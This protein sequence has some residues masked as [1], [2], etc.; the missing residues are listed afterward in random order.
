M[1]AR[2]S[3]NRALLYDLEHFSSALTHTL[4]RSFLLQFPEWEFP[5]DWI[6]L[7]ILMAQCLQPSAYIRTK[8]TVKNNAINVLSSLTDKAQWSSLCVLFNFTEQLLLCYLYLRYASQSLFFIF[9][10]S[11]IQKPLGKSL[12]C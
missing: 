2:K 11:V 8:H 10:I 6:S 12:Y 1:D 9:L 4:I 3:H 5:E 7:S